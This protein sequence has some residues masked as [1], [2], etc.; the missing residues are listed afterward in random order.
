MMETWSFMNNCWFQWTMHYRRISQGMLSIVN[1]HGWE[2]P[3][4]FYDRC[5]AGMFVFYETRNIANSF[6]NLTL[7]LVNPVADRLIFASLF[8]PSNM[9]RTIGHPRKMVDSSG[10]YIYLRISWGMLSI[11][12]VHCWKML[13]WTLRSLQSPNIF[14]TIKGSSLTMLSRLF[15]KGKFT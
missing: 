9:M 1:V 13:Q 7:W 6:D 11:V 8:F 12:N 15:L 3:V 2:M 14:T 10:S 4:D 5:K